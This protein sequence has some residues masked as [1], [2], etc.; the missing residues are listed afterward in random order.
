MNSKIVHIQKYN[1]VKLVDSE[2]GKEIHLGLDLNEEP[3]EVND[4]DDQPTYIVKLSQ[5]CKYAQLLSNYVMQHPTEFL[6][7]DVINNNLLWI[8]WTSCQFPTSKNI[9]RRQ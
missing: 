3:M 9:I 2:W 8:Y 7:V 6:V 5:A 1:M 4:V